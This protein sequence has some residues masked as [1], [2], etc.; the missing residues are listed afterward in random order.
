MFLHFS[1]FLLSKVFVSFNF[2][3]GSKFTKMVSVHL[4]SQCEFILENLSD[5]AVDKWDSFWEEICSF[6]WK[7]FNWQKII[8]SCRL[9]RHQVGHT[10]LTGKL[11][12]PVLRKSHINRFDIRCVILFV[13]LL[14][15]LWFDFYH[16]ISCQLETCK[17][18]RLESEQFGKS[19][20]S[21]LGESPHQC[22]TC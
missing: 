6:Q 11:Q 18:A 14:L 17:L 19:F 13:P 2:F 1:H 5:W 3:R 20:P 15:L 22:T 21:N 10:E 4:L 16:P 7:V 9:T 12:K 8:N